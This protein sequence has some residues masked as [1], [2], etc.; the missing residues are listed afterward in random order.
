MEKRGLPHK[1]FEKGEDMKKAYGSMSPEEDHI[2]LLEE[3]AGSINSGLAC[4]EMMRMAEASGD[5]KLRT[6]ARVLDVWQV[7][8]CFLSREGS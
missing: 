7:P 8:A 3:T 5:W 1:F 2:G 4:E 6:N